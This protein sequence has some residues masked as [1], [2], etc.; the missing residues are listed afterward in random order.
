MIAL[1]EINIEIEIYL[2]NRFLED[3]SM[4]QFVKHTV[5]MLALIAGISFA[6]SAS[7]APVIDIA[8]NFSYD[9]STGQFLYD[10]SVM[11]VE[12]I[13][14]TLIALEDNVTFTFTWNGSAFE[15]YQLTSDNGTILLSGQRLSEESLSE[16]IENV[17]YTKKGGIG[18]VPIS[19]NIYGYFTVTEGT[20]SSYFSSLVDFSSSLIKFSSSS[21]SLSEDF[22]GTLE[23]AKFSAAVPIPGTWGLLGFSLIAL[24]GFRRRQ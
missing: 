23:G 13:D 5:F 22:S 7:A 12:G 20:L 2:A 1:I 15:S 18:P 8:G 24:A 14:P 17:A 19:G 3:N 16:G 6:A 11:S 10:A 4:V 9:S 21:G